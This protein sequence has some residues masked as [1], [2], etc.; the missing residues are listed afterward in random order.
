[1]LLKTATVVDMLG[2]SFGATVEQVFLANCGP[3]LQSQFNHSGFSF[4]A[5][6]DPSGQE[7]PSAN[8]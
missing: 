4:Y 3:N 7:F 1:M 6:G 8:N 5:D 2:A